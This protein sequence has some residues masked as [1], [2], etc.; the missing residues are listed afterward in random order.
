MYEKMRVYA[1]SC[2]EGRA[3]RLRASA[4]PLNLDIEVV[5]S[6]LKDDIEVIRR[7]WRIFE[8]EMSYPTGLAATIGH[9]RAM[10]RL[11]DS[12]EP[13]GIIVEDDVR[14]HKNF[15]TVVE[16]LAPLLQTGEYDLLSLGF[17]NL[18]YGPFRD[19]GG[20]EVSYHQVPI[21]NPWGAQ[22]YM[23]TREYADYF[24]KRCSKDDLSET[25]HGNFVTDWVIFDTP[26]RRLTT[27]FPYALEAPDEQ[28]I[29][30]STNKPN[31]WLEVK[32][33]EYCL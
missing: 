22:C 17:V 30:G 10:Q 25:Y 33:E 31:L 13:L 14:F 7:G 2:N 11:V 15:N 5:P 26:C 19:V 8:K 27:R 4:A 21:S 32:A 9:I 6:P 16:S 18:P 3:D 20:I 29:A 12:G 28:S 23:V 1:V 24:T